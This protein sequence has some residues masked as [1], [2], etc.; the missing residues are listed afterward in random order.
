M[1][2]RNARLSRFVLPLF[3]TGCAL[4]TATSSGQVINE[5]LKILADDGAAGDLFGISIAIADGLVAVGS[6]ADDNANGN[7]SGS[8][9]LFDLTTGA[10]LFKLVAADGDAD[11]HFGTSV[12][13]ADGIVAVGA[14]DD[15][16]N[17][18]QSGSAYLFDASTGVQIA[19]LLPGDGA[20]DDQFGVSIAIGSGFVAVAAWRD[21]DT[22]TDSGSAYVFDAA[23]GIQIAKLRANDPAAR[24]YFGFSIATADGVVA[25]GAEGKDD[26]AINS[27][28][29][30]LFDA[31]TGMQIHKLLTVDASLGSRIGSSIA[32]ADGVVAVGARGDNDN[33]SGAGA[34][35]LFDAATG[36]QLAKLKATDGARN[37]AFGFAVAIAG[38]I[39]AVGATGDQ[40]NGTN[41]GSAYTFKY[42]QWQPDFKTRTE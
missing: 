26:G 21:D 10:Q 13:I 25:V 40:D 32:I 12:A 11:D 24:D 33:G 16:D 6:L 14:I 15:D 18:Q 41:S 36:T 23:T 31:S 29:A 5:E 30:Y 28:A 9:Y 17:G 38:G 35:F 4:V 37:D 39:V 22:A 42:G 8:V 20:P 1:R 7:A 34:A 2:N 27:G 19:K 3:V